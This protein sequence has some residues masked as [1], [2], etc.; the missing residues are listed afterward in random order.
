M[1]AGAGYDT[2]AVFGVAG[3]PEAVAASLSPPMHRAAF[4]ALG[5]EHAYYVPLGLRESSAGKALRS[6]PRLGFRGVNVTTPFKRVAAEIAHVGSERV[7]RSGSANTLTIDRSGR[8][9][10]ASTDGQ[11]VIEAIT[12]QGQELAGANVVMLGAGGVARDIAVALD[13]AGVGTLTIWN[14]SSEH[15]ADVAAL[16]TST[17]T[18]VVSEIAS[19]PMADVVIGTIPL[20]A[21]AELDLSAVRAE[22]A[23]D[24]AYSSGSAGTALRSTAGDSIDGREILAR[25]GALS[26]SIWFGVEPPLEAMLAA[27]RA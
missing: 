2:P 22:L 21:Y 5:M 16:P 27:V 11:A 19:L 26:F 18:N 1:A 15:A 7:E 10:A 17:S 4:D 25:Q 6:L 14:R 8:I 9:H 23:V 20:G 24:L 13:D 3:L 12:A